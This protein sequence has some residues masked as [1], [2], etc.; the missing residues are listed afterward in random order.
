MN[1]V[2]VS[3]RSTKPMTL[4]EL[5]AAYNAIIPPQAKYYGLPYDMSRLEGDHCDCQG[6]GEFVLLPITDRAVQEGG[7]RYM[8]C[9]KCGKYSHL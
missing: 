7:K 4:R 1:T 3:K 2:Y 9:R 6:N 5:T 8:Y